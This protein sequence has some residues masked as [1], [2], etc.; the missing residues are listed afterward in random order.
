[1]S[2]YHVSG[3]VLGPRNTPHYKAHKPQG[4][5]QAFL[6][7]SLD[8]GTILPGLVW[9]ANADGPCKL[10]QQARLPQGS[11]GNH[12]GRSRLLSGAPSSL[13]LST[14]R[15]AISPLLPQ[16]WRR[17]PPLPGGGSRGSRQ[18]EPSRR[19][20]LPVAAPLKQR[21]GTEES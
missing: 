19:R 6:A 17:C 11:C 9:L 16:E 7:Y 15:W 10:V 5:A 20:P 1:M 12:R 8:L 14:E 4:K 2:I 21:V 13:L 18:P 3:T